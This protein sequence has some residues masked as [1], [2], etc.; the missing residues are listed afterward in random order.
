MSSKYPKT[1]YSCN[2]EKYVSIVIHDI[3]TREYGFDSEAKLD[4][5]LVVKAAST[6]LGQHISNFN[7][8]HIERK[9]LRKVAFFLKSKI[10][11]VNKELIQYRLKSS[12]SWAT[13]SYEYLQSHVKQNIVDC[14]PKNFELINDSMVMGNYNCL[15]TPTPKGRMW[16]FCFHCCKK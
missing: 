13:K 7:N 9:D 15:T 4:K 10:E 2:W 5:D 11:K 12:H 8:L 1:H 3:F 14:N 6:V 16:A